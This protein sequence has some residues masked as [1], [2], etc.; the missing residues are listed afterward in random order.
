[1]PRGEVAGNEAHPAVR[2]LVEM[3]FAEE[4]CRQ[5]L[6]THKGNAFIFLKAFVFVSRKF[7]LCIHFE[8]RRSM[9]VYICILLYFCFELLFLKAMKAQQLRLY[10]VLC[11]SMESEVLLVIEVGMKGAINIQK[12]LKNIKILL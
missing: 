1:M 9:F 5:A 12:Y 4:D 7:Y 10:L 11:K 3:G 8:Q 2:R 6:L